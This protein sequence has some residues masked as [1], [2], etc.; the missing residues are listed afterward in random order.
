MG[1]GRGTIRQ[2]ALTVPQGFYFFCWPKSDVTL[3]P[4]SV[5]LSASA[6]RYAPEGTAHGWSGQPPAAEAPVRSL[7]LALSRLLYR[8][9]PAQSEFQELLF[10]CLS[11]CLW[12]MAVRGGGKRATWAARSARHP[13]SWESA[14][15]LSQ[16]SQYS[17]VP[18]LHPS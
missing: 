16:T 12:L 2:Q 13:L 9:I 14:A 5:C 15:S 11:C 10:A 6:V 18:G 7:T 3:G 8:V 17:P 1:E 4:S